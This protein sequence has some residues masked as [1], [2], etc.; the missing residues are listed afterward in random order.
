LK[1]RDLLLIV[2]VALAG[3]ALA[4]CPARNAPIAKAPS[5]V[6]LLA[7]AKADLVTSFNR[8]AESLRSINAGVTIQLTSASS[9]TGVI[10]QYHQVNGFILAQKPDMVRVIGQLPV[11]GTTI[12]N[13]VSDGKTFAIYVPSKN[14]FLT[15]PATLEKPSEKPV[16]NLRPQHL[17]DA[18]FWQ[19]IAEGAPVLFE[20][21]IDD[22]KSFY[23]LTVAA[24]ASGATGGR[25]GAADW[26]IS[27]KIWFERTGLTMSRVQIYGDQGR[28]DS[29]T[30]YNQWSAFGAVQYP[31]QISL[32]RPVEGY[33]LGITVTKLT[34]NEPIE[35]S[36]FVLQEPPTAQ[37]IHVGEDGSAQ[38]N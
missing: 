14:Q 21:A 13:M 16:E 31:K 12:F 36:R 9:Y 27:R 17:M 32:E 5:K 34:A 24:R 18:I 25:G 23:V 15:G 4:G 35:A 30:H 11:I 20:Q 29:D 38:K 28:L 3:L 1:V 33:T 2:P 7:A 10:K 37:V 19:P 8:L 6:P 22:G 26:S